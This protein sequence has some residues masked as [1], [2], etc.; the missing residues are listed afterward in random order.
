MLVT[1]ALPGNGQDSLVTILDK[2]QY[3]QGDSILA[4]IYTEPYRKDATAQTLHLW[5]D[6]IKTGQRWKF[7][8]PFLKGVAASH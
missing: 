2:D 1:R 5:I 6:N 4:E 8:Y 3:V 7:R